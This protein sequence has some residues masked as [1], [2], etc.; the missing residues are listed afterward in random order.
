M[1]RLSALRNLLARKSVRVFPVGV[2][3][4][5][6]SG[7]L[8]AA[9]P[10]ASATTTGPYYLKESFASYRVGAPSLSPYDPVKETLGGREIYF[11]ETTFAH[12]KIRFKADTSKCVAAANNGDTVDIK[13]CS[14]ATGVVWVAHD[15]QDGCSVVLESQ[16]FSGKYLSGDG[17]GDQFHIRS[18]Q[19]NGWYQQFR[20]V[21]PSTGQVICF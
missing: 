7:L 20:P 14:S 11:D 15:G 6:V 3:A 16:H 21:V 9:A 18:Y 2:T 4:I 13:P 1:K 19:A 17:N 8:L 12:Y 10:P 5:A